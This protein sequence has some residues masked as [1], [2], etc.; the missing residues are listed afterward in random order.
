MRGTRGHDDQFK[1]GP[2][3]RKSGWCL[4]RPLPFKS[5]LPLAQPGAETSAWA[6]G[7]SYVRIGTSGVINLVLRNLSSVA[8]GGRVRER[9]PAGLWAVWHG[10]SVQNCLSQFLEPQGHDQGVQPSCRVDIHSSNIP[11][12]QM[13]LLTHSNSQV[14]QESS[15]HLCSLWTSLSFGVS[16]YRNEPL[17]GAY[18]VLVKNC[19]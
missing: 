14:R 18:F 9:R 5:W 17:L 6:T 16:V 10:Y 11:L 12:P 8:A 2:T 4:F 15:R 3:E 19:L 7:D 13:L 1:P